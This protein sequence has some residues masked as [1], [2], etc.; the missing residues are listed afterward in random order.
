L[1]TVASILGGIAPTKVK[2]IPTNTKLRS[3]R[4]WKT[5]PG[6]MA[7]TGGVITVVTGLVVVLHQSGFFDGKE[8]QLPQNQN[9]FQAQTPTGRASN[10]RVERPAQAGS[11]V[12]SSPAMRKSE[13]ASGP[14]VPA[15]VSEPLSRSK[16]V[17]LLAP[18]NG[19]HLVTASS[20]AWQATIDGR[21]DF[22]QISYGT[23][24]EAVYAFKDERQAT[25]DLFTILIVESWHSNVKEFELLAGNDS[26][27]GAFESIGRF[28]TQNMKLFKTPY[29]EFKFAPVKA[30]YL[31]M[32]LISAYGPHPSV[33]EFQLFGN[34]D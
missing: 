20:D 6:I 19:G 14:P 3:R 15:T 21:E 4:W 33:L 31:K 22:S 9:H 26:P 16:R 10:E 11:P 23:G 13:S 29:Q 28:Q 32:K 7:A 18:E 12:P 27:T 5:M 17:N 1:K 8:K 30:R 24:T 25:F 34:L 2:Q